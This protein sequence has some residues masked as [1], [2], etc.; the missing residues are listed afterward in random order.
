MG[1]AVSQPWKI[2]LRGPVRELDHLFRE[3]VGGEWGG[4]R[5]LDIECERFDHDIEHAHYFGAV[6]N[7]SAAR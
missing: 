3:R 2:T 6:T 7:V 1:A 5:L 4:I